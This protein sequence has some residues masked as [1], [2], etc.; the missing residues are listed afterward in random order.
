MKTTA[1]IDSVV[2]ELFGKYAVAKYRPTP[3]DILKEDK[4]YCRKCGEVKA[5]KS[6]NGIIGA[7]VWKTVLCP[8]LRDGLEKERQAEAE[9]AEKLRVIR[10]KESYSEDQFLSVLGKRYKDV[11]FSDEFYSSNEREKDFLAV[12]SRLQKF[13]ENFEKASERNIGWWLWSPNRGNGKTS[14]AACVRNGLLDRGISCIVTSVSDIHQFSR[15]S[16][17]DNFRKCMTCRCL[18]I[19]DIGLDKLSDWESETFHKVINHR[20]LSDGLVTCYTSNFPMESLRDCNV[21]VATISRM[22]EVTPQIFELKGS[23]MRVR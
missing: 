16:A 8:C 22:D 10:I 20:Y 11:R 4:I 18:I 21:K 14:L 7:D 15:E 17:T 23:S 5:V 1:S 2:G 9:E 12:S 13:V 6:W 3:D 19:D